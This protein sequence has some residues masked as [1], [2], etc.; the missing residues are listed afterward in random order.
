[1]VEQLLNSRQ[2]AGWQPRDL[3]E[4]HGCGPAKQLLSDHAAS[5]GNGPNLM[6][7]GPPGT[8]KTTLIQTYVRALICPQRY[9]EPVRHCGQCSACLSFNAHVGDDGIFAAMR[10]HR[11]DQEVLHY[12][13]VNCGSVKRDELRAIVE[14]DRRE[15]AGRFVIYLQEAQFLA[16]RKLYRGLL[17][18]IQNEDL[19]IL[20]LADTAHPEDLNSMFLRRFTRTTTTPLSEQELA[21]FLADRCRQWS[22]AVDDPRTLAMLSQQCRGMISEAIRVLAQATHGKERILTRQLVEHY[23]FL[24]P[25]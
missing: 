13:P 17:A 25:S 24:P 18:V 14:E 7:M 20:W 9:G 4:I 22:I 1:M 12:Y 5:D 23:P 8:G 15:Y 16:V 2:I 19:N 10:Q 6:V 21:L 11:E 3:S